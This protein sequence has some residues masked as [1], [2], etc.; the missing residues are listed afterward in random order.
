MPVRRVPLDDVVE[1]ALA[2]D[3]HNGTLVI[4][5]LAAARLRDRGWAGLRSVD[6]PWHTRSRGRSAP[7][8]GSVG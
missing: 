2:G 1:A 6:E 5:V 3:V 8:E 4:A 7:G